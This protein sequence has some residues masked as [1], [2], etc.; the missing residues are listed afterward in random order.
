LFLGLSL[1]FAAPV[2]VGPGMHAVARW[3]LTVAGAL[4]L[5]GTAGPIVGDMAIQRIGILGY[6]VVLPVA[7]ATLA[8]VF[9]RD[10]RRIRGS[11][12]AAAIGEPGDR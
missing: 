2:F 3:W 8:V 4:C 10:G 11:R 1:L 5:A 7:S 9:H 12:P 6:G